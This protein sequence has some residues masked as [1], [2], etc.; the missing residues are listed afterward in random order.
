MHEATNILRH[1]H[2]IISVMVKTLEE[3]LADYDAG[4]ITRI[5]DMP[6]AANFFLRFAD[7]LH[8]AKEER[9]LFP[10]VL[11]LDPSM[12]DTITRLVSDHARFRIALQRL[13]EAEVAGDGDTYL[14]VVRGYV[15]HIR[16]HMK[17]EDTILFP[18]ADA[19][20]TAEE[21]RELAEELVAVQES[22]M[23][24]E[25]VSGLEDFATSGA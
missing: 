23:S 21:Q 14:E 17:R 25:E 3:A 10:A 20:L 4:R 5:C 18:A 19:A 2:V 9:V 1:E 15:A 11:A 12:E 13:R 24:P 16:D 7:Y 22:V 6:K 8:H